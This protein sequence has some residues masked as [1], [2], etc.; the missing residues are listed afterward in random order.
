MNKPTEADSTPLFGTTSDFLETAARSPVPSASNTTPTDSKSS[1]S[2]AANKDF[3]TSSVTP[4]SENKSNGTGSR[5]E[6]SALFSLAS[7]SH[8]HEDAVINKPATSDSSIIDIKSLANGKSAVDAILGDGGGIAS[9]LAAP[10]LAPVPAPNV[11]LAKEP[12]APKTN[13]TVLFSV[14]GATVIV[15]AGGLGAVFM[16]KSSP[17][18]TAVNGEARPSTTPSGENTAANGAVA[19][20]ANANTNPTPVADIGANANAN[21]NHG[22]GAS[23]AARTGPRTTSR[24]RSSASSA[25]Q[26]EAPAQQAAPAAPAQPQVSPCV[27]NCRGDIQC[28]LRCASGG[29]AAPSPSSGGG[30]DTPSRN[31]VLAA[32]NGVRSSVTACAAS[33]GS[34]GSFQMTVTFA[35][36]GRVTTANAGAPL[37]ATPAGSCAARAVR[38]AQV[39]P[40]SRPTFQVVFPF[41]Y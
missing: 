3:F 29:S 4:S 6:N 26:A 25:T 2:D 27:R 12:E 16:L 8:G 21:A 31:D 7:L 10:V 15:V 14:L 40:F 41:S 1:A 38:A 23:N 34:H 24:S 37:A 39:P 19:A 35:S 30:A 5:N 32:M 13:K 36:S 11:V 18:Q 28:I 33:L 20:N 22:S 9:P 17:T